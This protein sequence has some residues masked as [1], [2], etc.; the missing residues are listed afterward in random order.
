MRNPW[1]MP[2]TGGPSPAPSNKRSHSPFSDSSASSRCS[3]GEH[4]LVPI[5][6]LKPNVRKGYQ[7]KCNVC[8]RKTCVV[9]LECSRAPHSWWPVCKPARKY[10]GQVRKSDCH[11]WHMLNPDVAPRGRR[12]NKRARTVPVDEDMCGACSD[13]GEGSSDHELSGDEDDS[14]DEDDD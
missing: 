6:T 1:V 13:E 12:P 3:N 8:N 10:R 2:H 7:L 9:C 11:E 5:R 14:D 4:H